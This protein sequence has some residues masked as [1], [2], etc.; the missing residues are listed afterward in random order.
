MTRAS[1]LRWGTDYPMDRWN[2]HAPRC[3]LG[4]LRTLHITGR[5]RL[6]SPDPPGEVVER[7]DRRHTHIHRADTGLLVQRPTPP[8]VGQLRTVVRI[9]VRH[10]RIGEGAPLPVETSGN[11][12]RIEPVFGRRGRATRSIL[13][14]CQP[15]PDDVGP[16]LGAIH[17]L[18][19]L[20]LQFPLKRVWLFGAQRRDEVHGRVRMFVW[21]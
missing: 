15:S 4:K 2:P 11:V 17:Q 21:H 14:R 7:S 12:G 3:C 8:A 16:F 19:G 20:V 13:Y 6:H 1:T 18:G 9:Q 5:V 10:G